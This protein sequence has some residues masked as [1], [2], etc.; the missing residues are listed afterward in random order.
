MLWRTSTTRPE[1]RQSPDWL[2]YVTGSLTHAIQST[3]Q[4]PTSTN[5]F[6]KVKYTTQLVVHV[7]PQ[8]KPAPPQSH[9]LVLT[10]ASPPHP[11][12]PH[13]ANLS[14]LSGRC[15]PPKI[16]LSKPPRSEWG[17]P[18]ECSWICPKTARR[19]GQGAEAHGVGRGREGRRV[20]KRK[21]CS[22]ARSEHTRN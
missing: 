18:G 8:K 2:P 22:T 13:A 9:P 20:G 5:M 15:Q 12:F 6:R 14:T 19:L 10:S 4:I 3:P 11:P 17:A 16:F 7:K 21:S 1:S